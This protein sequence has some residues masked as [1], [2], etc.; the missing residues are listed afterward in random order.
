MQIHTLITPKRKD[1]KRIGRGGRRGTTSGR[2]SNG[3]K[4]RTGASVD[5]LF[6]GGRSSLIDRLKKLKG[7]KS[8]RA[9]R[10]T[11]TLSFLEK[12]FDVGETVSRDTLIGKKLFSPKDVKGGFKVV[13]SG[14]LTKALV[15]HEKIKLSDTA[16]EVVKKAGG[17]ITEEKE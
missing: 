3:Q 13:S 11:V 16:L 5:P 10:V 17:T 12:H 1:R 4:S 2:G 7:F 14:T 8:P 15:F 9:K 6:E